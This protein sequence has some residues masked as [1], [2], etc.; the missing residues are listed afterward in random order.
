MNF[1]LVEKIARA[2]LYE[3]YLLYP[4]RLSAMK[5]WQRWTFGVL[6][7]KSYSS[8]Q[9]GTEAWT[10]QTECLVLGGQTHRQD[11]FAPTLRVKVRFLHLRAQEV[12]KLTRPLSR[13][14]DDVEPTFR[15]VEVLKVGE[16]L[17]WTRQE[18]VEREVT[19]ADLKLSEILS[20][21]ERVTFT[22]PPWQEL[23]PIHGPTGEVVGV[24]V[25]RQWPIEGAVE[26]TAEYAGKGVFKIAVRI[27]NLTPPSVAVGAGFEEVDGVSRDQA[28]RQSFVSTH[29]IL[30]VQQGEFI[31]L[32]DPPDRFREMATHCSN[33]GTWPVLVGKEGERNILLSSPII[34]YDYPQIAPE[35]TGDFFDGTETEELLMLR[36][37]A[38][39]DEEKQ[40]MRQADE[41]T[42]A[43]LD[44]IE[45][46][47]KEQLMNLHG[48]IRNLQRIDERPTMQ[49]GNS[50]EETP[51]PK[52]VC[53]GGIDLKPGDRVRLRP[54][55][56]G[57]DIFDLVL[58]GKTA[59]IQSIEQDYEDRVYLVVTVDEDPGKEFGDQRM[60]AHRFFF[61]PEEVEP[62]G[63]DEKEDL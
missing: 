30:G 40:E 32:L 59:T 24:I 50:P 3:G 49:N 56:E 11:Y 31:S 35:S 60:P 61:S 28:L 39:T 53:V 17:F 55:R 9:R 23:K 8:A 16:K 20:R 47:S 38:L 7:P 6:Y 21:P 15:V 44:R 57:T 54:R 2:I 13:L 46:L 63:E 37:L 42:H 27:L 14:P 12:G 58:E 1:A 48:A 45:T 52:S 19:L 25:G 18:G 33:V 51:P 29:T 5:N 26:V 4:Y 10:M 36:I 34:L 22:F 41:R 62:L 43:L